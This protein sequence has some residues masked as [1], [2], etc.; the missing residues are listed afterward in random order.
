M[1]GVAE[2][3]VI[4]ECLRILEAQIGAIGILLEELLILP[5]RRRIAAIPTENTRV[6]NARG[7]VVGTQLQ[8]TLVEIDGRVVILETCIRL[9]Q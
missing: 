2:I 6:L 7:R 5:L 4:R 1:H 9:G 3:R 8:V